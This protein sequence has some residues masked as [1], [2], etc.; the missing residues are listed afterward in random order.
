MSVVLNKF[1]NTSIAISGHTDSV[2]TLQHN[3]DLSQKYAYVI[4][5]N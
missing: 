3:M 5:M 2:G 1:K 4:M